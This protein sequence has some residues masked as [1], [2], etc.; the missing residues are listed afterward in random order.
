M[1]IRPAQQTF[2]TTVRLSLSAERKGRFMKT[3][4]KKIKQSFKSEDEERAFWAHHSPINVFDASKAR[5]HP[6]PI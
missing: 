2:G 5:Q 3:K 1:S 6:S 4:P